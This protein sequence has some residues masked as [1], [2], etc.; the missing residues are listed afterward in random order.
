MK[1]RI[2]A[3]NVEQSVEPLVEIETLL[4]NLRS[5]WGEIAGQTSSAPAPQK[6]TQLQDQDLL[7]NAPNA[8]TMQLKSLNISI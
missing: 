4:E 3:A 5:A 2:F 6:G 1:R 7:G 8:A